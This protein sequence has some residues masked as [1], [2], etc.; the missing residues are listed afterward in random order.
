MANE[1]QATANKSIR[2]ALGI[3]NYN[4]QDTVLI[5][6]DLQGR[7]V[8][9]SRAKAQDQDITKGASYIDAYKEV[10]NPFG[11]FSD[12]DTGYLERVKEISQDVN[13]VS[14]LTTA[15]QNRDARQF[16]ELLVSR[17]GKKVVD[18]ISNTPQDQAAL[19]ASLNSYFLYNNWEQLSDAQKA[20]GIANVGVQA[21]EGLT[22]DSVVKKVIPG[23][24]SAFDGKG[25]TVGQALSI[26]KLG[27]NGYALAA[28]WDQLDAVQKLAYGSGTLS[29]AA[30]LGESLG[31][32]GQNAQNAVIPNISA[33]SL[34][35]VGATS[36]PAYGVGA[37]VVSPEG[38]IPAGYSQVGTTPGGES[39][40]VPQG[41]E[42]TAAIP[43]SG[44]VGGSGGGGGGAGG[45]FGNSQGQGSFAQTA[46][47]AASF[48]SAINAGYQFSQ[49]YGNMSD[50]ER[51]ISATQ[52]AGAAATA[53]NAVGAGIPGAA[54]LT[55]VGAIAGGA[56]QAYKAFGTGGASGRQQ[57]AMGGASMAAGMMALGATNPYLL[58][59][60]VALSV[61]GG[62]VKKG[63]HTHQ[64]MRDQ[65]R[66]R[67]VDSG[68]ASSDYKITLPDGT[69]ADIG[70]DGNYAP[71]NYTDASKKV[72]GGKE[73]LAPYDIDYTSDMDYFSGLAG[74]GL[75]VALNGDFSRG[76]Q[77]VGGQLGN[78]ALG[79]VGH[80]ATLNPDNFDKVMQNHRA[81]YS[82]A[83][84]KNKQEAYQIANTLYAEGK[85]N[86]SQL[87]SLYQSYDIVF[88]ND[89]NK[90][91]SLSA[92]RF[93]GVELASQQQDP[94][95][96]DASQITTRGA[97][98][99][100]FTPM[101]RA[102]AIKRNEGTYGQYHM[103]EA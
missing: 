69:T 13:L 101:D 58:A 36:A 38:T 64:P 16:S 31:L 63:K 2:N 62:S 21:Y 45:S 28:N 30:A 89:F 102:E 5:G 68:L 100:M 54:T 74:V 79:T 80:G 97:G 43:Q 92:G 37:V 59:G 26:T 35:A 56:Y 82:R 47:Q 85:L 14:Q 24:E 27:Y 46:G 18:K 22:G 40:A 15:A 11:I 17:Y 7:E 103:V 23:S 60:V 4:T 57:G 86:D 41:L 81:L 67:L 91:N 49:N 98:E 1:S 52:T 29:Q 88:D 95:E 61:A 3:G 42:K 39:I 55:G 8:Y 94:D 20:I 77:Q 10:L 73:D 34:A 84:V 75:S 78:A 44:G 87:V 9:A 93:K 76:V 71:R 25:V 32:I 72:T 65:A 66:A 19:N 6:N 33:E 99:A 96:R 83:G 50:E 12:E 51:A 48:A 53:A 70:L 90:A